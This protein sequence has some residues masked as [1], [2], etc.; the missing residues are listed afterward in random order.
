[1]ALGRTERAGGRTVDFWQSGSEMCVCER[2]KERERDCLGSRELF[3]VGYY[4]EDD[5][6]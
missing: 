3:K 1:V 6:L 5:L 4:G 2:E